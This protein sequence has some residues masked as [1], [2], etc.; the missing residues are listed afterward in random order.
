MDGG[1]SIG[2]VNVVS[3]L[4][5]QVT[6]GFTE[7][8]SGNWYDDNII[9]E[10]FAYLTGNRTRWA[11]G[12]A[13]HL[14][15]LPGHSGD[16]LSGEDKAATQRNRDLLNIMRHDIRRGDREAVKHLMQFRKVLAR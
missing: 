15:H 5:L 12:P 10:G 16:H 11:S 14:Y 8:T 13:V 6:G 4:T 9:E 2:A 1:K 7:A 3:R